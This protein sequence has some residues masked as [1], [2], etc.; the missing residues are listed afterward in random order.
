[1]TSAPAAE[2]G[3]R[4]RRLSEYLDRLPGGTAAY[5]EC[6]AR[7]GVVEAVLSA[8]PRSEDPAP[9][10]VA[11]LLTMPRGPWIPEVVF[12]AAMLALAD[13]EGWTE[14][15]IL[16]WHRALNRRLFRGPV[17]RAVMAFFT[18]RALL[19]HGPSRWNA[20]HAGTTLEVSVEGDH[21][22]SAVLRHPPHLFTPLLLRVYA[23]AFGAALEN[24]RATGRIA[25]ELVEAGESSA[26][27]VARW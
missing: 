16:A 19:E 24:A 1:M 21:G 5:P 15:Q 2:L 14:I 26:R 25:V 20:F 12:N 6:L 8:V 18:P 23:E 4:Y 17:Y 27:F 3:S 13:R 10:L 11:D 22:G 9:Q 7:R